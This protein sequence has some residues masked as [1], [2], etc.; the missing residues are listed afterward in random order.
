MSIAGR[1]P[2]LAPAV[3]IVGTRFADDEALSFARRLAAEL[4]ACERVVVSGGA[5]GID[6]AAHEGALD[7]GGRTIAV[8]ATGLDRAY[9]A[10]HAPLF[11]RIAESGALLSEFDGRDVPRKGWAF[12]KRNRLV[13]ALAPTVV[14]V[15]AP[16]RSG[17]LSTARWAKRLKRRV[18]VVPGA[19][20]DARAAGCLSLLAEGAEICASVEDVLSVGPSRGRRCRTRVT[21]RPSQ[22]H[23][24]DA[25]LS[26]QASAVR[27]WL[28][29][30]RAHP[31]EIS[32]ALDMPAA[33]VQE[34]L[35]V[36]MLS[37]ACRQRA[38]GSYETTPPA[39]GAFET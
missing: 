38:D 22:E 3:A 11:G 14:I 2:S 7:A 16:A 1:I 17:A 36:L 28:R 13:A 9:P 8:L 25:G 20:W 35:L 19:P 26:N 27:L 32:A 31:D 33:E 21:G 4:A 10:H 12:L 37:G 5:A 24:N 30:R 18:F 6:A 39:K 34:A 15:Q 23:K 29:V